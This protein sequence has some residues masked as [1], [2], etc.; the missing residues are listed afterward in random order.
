MTLAWREA[1]IEL[2]GGELAFS[3][4]ADADRVDQSQELVE[5]G[6]AASGFWRG[7][8]E[9]L[10]RVP[11]SGPERVGPHWRLAARELAVE[12]RGGVRGG[13]SAS[14]WARAGVVGVADAVGE[15]LEKIGAAYA[16]VGGEQAGVGES[17]DGALQGR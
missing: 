7:L 2:L 12:W 10:Q 15:E 3:R 9:R 11:A 16:A 1:L 5:C 17:L 8:V 14:R 4:L 13:H 6:V